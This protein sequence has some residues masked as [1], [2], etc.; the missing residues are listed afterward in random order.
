MP[1]GNSIAVLNLLRLHQYTLNSQYLEFAQLSLKWVTPQLERAPERLSDMLI[2]L[3]YFY[4]DNKEIVLVHPNN[5][6]G[7][8]SL[9]DLLKQTFLP[10]SIIIIA[11]ENQ[12]SATS[13][14]VPSVAGKVAI[15]NKSTAYVCYIG[16][17]KLPAQN[18]KLLK[19]QLS[20]LR[21]F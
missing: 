21:K 1:S 13:K 12:V 5:K 2:A 6:T 10:N 19:R 17:C 20:E 7:N 18:I 4:E 15:N 11:Q 3:D 8:K 9:E 16:I 14:I